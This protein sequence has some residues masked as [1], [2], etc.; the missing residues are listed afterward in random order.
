VKPALF[1]NLSASF[2]VRK[3]GSDRP[4]RYSERMKSQP[5]LKTF[6]HPS[7]CGKVVLIIH[8]VF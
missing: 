4:F 6:P 7:G 1:E 3:G 2:R 8:L 5:C